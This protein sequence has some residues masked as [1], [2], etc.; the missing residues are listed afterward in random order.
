MKD[1]TFSL[2][3]LTAVCGW[4][5]V[6]SQARVTPFLG[7]QTTTLHFTIVSVQISINCKY[8][9]NVAEILL[10]QAPGDA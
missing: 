9:R 7:K 8:E 6:V 2:S 5:D 3:L 4:V 10:L 1:S